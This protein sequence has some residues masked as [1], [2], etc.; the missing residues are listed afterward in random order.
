[1]AYSTISVAITVIV[2]N[3]FA[4]RMFAI[5]RESVNSY[6]VLMLAYLFALYR[7][8]YS[9]SYEYADSR[10]SPVSKF[11]IAST[12]TTVSVFFAICYT[13]Q[14][15]PLQLRPGAGME[16][17]TLCFVLSESIITGYLDVRAENEARNAAV[18]S[19]IASI[20][21][22]HEAEIAALKEKLAILEAG[23]SG[24]S[25]TE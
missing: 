22:K 10:R 8:A 21:L 6:N 15:T 17:F 20:Q 19:A 4:S 24:V 9:L 25:S 5:W 16:Y 3:Y 11:L 13:I 2:Y 12:A 23:A 14:S 18:D 7:S 1:M